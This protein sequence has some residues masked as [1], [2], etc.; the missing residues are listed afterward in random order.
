VSVGMCSGNSKCRVFSAGTKIVVA[1]NLE[2]T[3]DLAMFLKAF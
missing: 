3:I 2:N 1:K